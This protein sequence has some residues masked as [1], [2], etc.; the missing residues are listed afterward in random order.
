MKKIVFILCLI[1]FSGSAFG[2]TRLKC[3][4]NVLSADMTLKVIMASKSDGGITCDDPF[5]TIIELYS[6]ITKED[7]IWFK[8]IFN[9]SGLIK[10]FTPMV[11]LNSN[12]G[13]LMAAL[14]IAKTIRT[15]N[16]STVIVLE[17]SICYSSCVI[18]LAS[19]LQR[20]AY[21]KIGVHRPYLTKSIAIE[22]GYNDLFQFY[23][24]LYSKLEIYFK[25]V[26]INQS[27]LE[28]MWFT[29]S[30]NIKI[31]TE[32]E[33]K[34]SG[35]SEDDLIRHEKFN[36]K[37]RALCGENG[38]AWDRDFFKKYSA[39]L[40][41]DKS[42]GTSDCYNLVINHPLFKCGAIKFTDEGHIKYTFFPL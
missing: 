31:L 11:Y 3:G 37:L 16:S 9:L 1:C 42:K 6:T 32:N 18:V 26:N 40:V 8:K 23:D 27:I 33:L 39:C 41:N 36:I 10:P 20:A 25:E 19:G 17:N 15:K 21:G 34:E 38:P 30:D 14:S 35:L 7:A 24:D 4:D 12:G 13:D 28:K 2:E 29:S 22:Y 5:P